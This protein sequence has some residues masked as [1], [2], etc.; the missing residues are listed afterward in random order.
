MKVWFVTG[1]SSGFGKELVKKI[2]KEGDAVIA[3]ARNTSSLNDLNGEV[4]KLPLDVTN[5][6]QIKS[7]VRKAKQWKGRIDILVN[8]AG[9]GRISSIEDSELNDW[10]NIFAVNVFGLINVTKEITPIFRKQCSGQIINMGSIA[11]LTTRPGF[12]EYCATKYA[13]EA[14]TEVLQQELE[15]FKIKVSVIEPGVFG[16]NFGKN[17]SFKKISQP[18][19]N[20]VGKMQEMLPNI[21]KKPLGDP[22]K[23][24]KIIFKISRIPNPPLR[25]LLGSDAYQRALK[26][27]NE[28]KIEYTKFEK[29]SKSTDIKK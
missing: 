14:I 6:K 23:A 28:L 21:Y 29:I 9:V 18:Y 5:Q 15:E 1:C 16:T 26:K 27:I 13:V 2:L 25:L 19:K 12:G 7:T 24:A 3:T 20:T 10:Q 4:L 17:L 8:N 11:G 22:K